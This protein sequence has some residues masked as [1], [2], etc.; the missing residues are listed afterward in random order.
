MKGKA[1]GGPTTQV[2]YDWR[3]AWKTTWRIIPGLGSVVRITPIDK[4]T[5]R[6]FGRGTTLLIGRILTM[7]INRIQTGMIQVGCHS[8]LF[9][10]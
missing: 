7:V 6:P 5:K 1:V 4:P 3:M 10:V 2:R 8:H 9:V